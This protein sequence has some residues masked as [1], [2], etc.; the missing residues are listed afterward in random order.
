MKL[1]KTCLMEYPF[2]PEFRNLHCI[3][4]LLVKNATIDLI[5]KINFFCGPARQICIN[6][7][8]PRDYKMYFWGPCKY[9]RGAHDPCDPVTTR[10][11]L[12][13]AKNLT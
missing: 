7:Y 4:L 3:L 5:A 10:H 2:L 11:F 9:G 12:I 6:L 13:M 8:L 1:N